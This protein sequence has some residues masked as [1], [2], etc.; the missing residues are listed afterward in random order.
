[1]FQII[2][3]P[4][5]NVFYYF[6]FSITLA[7]TLDKVIG[8]EPTTKA[9]IIGGGVLAPIAPNLVDRYNKNEEN[10]DEELHSLKTDANKLENEIIRLGA[11]FEA[12]DTSDIM[13]S[14][15]K[16]ERRLGVM[17][18]KLDKLYNDEMGTSQN[19]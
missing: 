15:R 13:E 4:S 5:K 2:T 1:M 8:L 16:I 6:L 17:E 10:K 11:M 9:I 19:D 7:I 14:I 18:G 12:T 3:Q